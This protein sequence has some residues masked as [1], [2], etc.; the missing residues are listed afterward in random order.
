ME[1]QCPTSLERLKAWLLARRPD[2]ADV[3]LDTDLIE[4]RLL[5]SMAFMDFLLYIEELIGQEVDL[6]EHSQDWFRTLRGIRD[7]VLR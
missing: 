3:D 4:A 1:A 6:N 2:L 7:T 5:D